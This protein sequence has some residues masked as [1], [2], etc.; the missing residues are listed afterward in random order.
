MR[1]VAG[2]ATVRI[3]GRAGGCFAVVHGSTTLREGIKG[4]EAALAARA[5]IQERMN[6]ACSGAGCKR[7][8]AVQSMDDQKRYCW[9]HFLK[10][11]GID[12]LVYV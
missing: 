4:R 2:A 12:E 8:V 5:K 9:G 10:T 7:G 11:R 6:E 3:E 1:G